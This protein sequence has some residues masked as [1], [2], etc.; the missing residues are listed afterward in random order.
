[1]AD[2]IAA[3]AAGKITLSGAAEMVRL[4]EVYVKAG[5]ASDRETQGAIR[6]IH[7]EEDRLDQKNLR[8]RMGGFGL[9]V[10][11]R[12]P[13]QTEPPTGRD[14]DREL[15]PAVGRHGDSDYRHHGDPVAHF[16]CKALRAHRLITPRATAGKRIAKRARGDTVDRL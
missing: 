10:R 3:A 13:D 11:R 16:C 2:I 1:V 5:E 8:Q 6:Q 9:S 7:E 4:I 12:R 15:A 14:Q